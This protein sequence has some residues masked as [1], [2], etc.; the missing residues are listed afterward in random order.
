MS[1]ETRRTRKSFTERLEE[2][3]RE[4]PEFSRERFDP[5]G[6]IPYTGTLARMSDTG[7]LEVMEVIRADEVADFRQWCKRHWK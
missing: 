4:R 7:D 6:S 1:S 5:D 2:I 3:E